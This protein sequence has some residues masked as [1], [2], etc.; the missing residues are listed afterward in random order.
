M[1]FR[2]TL[3]LLQLNKILISNEAFISQQI[4]LPLVCL[5][6]LYIPDSERITIV[7]HPLTIR[8]VLLKH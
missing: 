3:N 6:N 8:K 4:S 7:L 1:N 5:D 2:T